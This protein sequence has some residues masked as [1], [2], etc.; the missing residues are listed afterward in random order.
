M[1]EEGGG[2]NLFMQIVFKLAFAHRV[3]LAAGCFVLAP[4]LDLDAVRGAEV[5]HS[6]QPHH[7]LLRHFHVRAANVEPR[8]GKTNHTLGTTRPARRT[9]DIC[10]GF[11][12]KVFESLAASR[13]TPKAPLRI[14]RWEDNAE[15]LTDV[16]ASSPAVSSCG[17]LSLAHLTSTKC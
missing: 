10:G 16:T 13:P 8:T 6:H 14:Q 9:P 12:S 1:E 3:A 2:V 7:V 15:T 4:V 17:A 11:R 5:L